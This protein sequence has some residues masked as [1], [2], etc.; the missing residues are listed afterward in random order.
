VRGCSTGLGLRRS[1]RRALHQAVPRSPPRLQE[2]GAGERALSDGAFVSPPS[3]LPGQRIAKHSGKLGNIASVGWRS[4]EFVNRYRPEPSRPGRVGSPVSKIDSRGQLSDARLYIDNLDEDG[5]VDFKGKA[6]AFVRTYAFNANEAYRNAQVNS[7]KQN[8]RIEHD[9]ALRSAIVGLM[10]DDTQLF[11]QF[12]D[13]SEFR[14]WLGD[15][16]FAATYQPQ[17][18]PTSDA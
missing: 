7:D 13:N 18:Q 5:Q 12:S 9:K 16:I 8:A 14:K 17:S 11:K 4:V 3:S 6:K 15:T 10:K 2:I 1:T